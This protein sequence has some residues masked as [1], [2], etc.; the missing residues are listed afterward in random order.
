ML[1]L[2]AALIVCCLWG[3]SELGLEDTATN[4]IADE[5]LE[6]PASEPISFWKDIA[7]MFSGKCTLCH[8]SDNATG[9]DLTHPFDPEVGIVSRETAWTDAD[10]SLIV[11]PGNPEN[12]FLLRKVGSVE[13][14]PVREGARM[15]LLFAKL[16]SDE[17]ASVRRWVQD[18]ANDDAVYRDQVA[19]LFGD[20]TSL[21]TSG[22]CSL[23][24]SPGSPIPDLTDPF[25][26]RGVVDKTNARGEP[27]V[28]P[29]APDSSLLVQKI[30]GR[31][32][33]GLSMPLWLEPFSPHEVRLIERWIREGARE[34]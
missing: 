15:P 13:L 16:N 3:C 9:V 2:G 20:G 5:D 23:C 8:H 18:G 28:V 19:P 30:E 32:T 14:D 12:S 33:A 25:G 24:H 17:I 1:R 11:D 34:N 29:G 10:Q 31:V 7:P 6:P 27:L 21:E 4:P 22:R 26:P